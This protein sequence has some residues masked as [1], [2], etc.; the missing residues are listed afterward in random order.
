M[1]FLIRKETD[2][3]IIFLT[4]LR[5]KY[6]EIKAKAS[7]P[8]KEEEVIKTYHTIM[9]F[10]KVARTEGL[11]ALEEELES[12]DITNDPQAFFHFMVMMIV[13]GTDAD[14]VEEIGMN[15]CIVFDLPS[16]DGLMNL[17]YYQGG[18]KIQAGD[19]SIQIDLCLKSMLS[20]DILKRLEVEEY[21]N[22]SLTSLRQAEKEQDMIKKLCEDKKDI[23][24][25]DHTIVNQT[26]ITLISISNRDIQRLLKEI[27]NND[28]SLAM[29]VLPGKVRFKIFD[30]IS[31]RLALT[32]AENMKYMGPIRLVDAKKAC[33][34]IMKQFIRLVD[35]TEVEEYDTS[36][37]KVVLDIYEREQK[38]NQDIKNKY[39]ELKKLID[40]IYQR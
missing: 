7:D 22:A 5:R 37:L 24:E 13:D 14:L 2:M 39:R 25:K 4:E 29:K 12:L 28:I 3:D 38:E 35:A 20:Q 15:R 30:N 40:E 10:Q 17:M 26:A 21:E 32:I 33:A 34:K 6:D 27:D 36:F 16:Y 18:R 11:L 23:D 19:A 8:A 9:R 1:V 31:K